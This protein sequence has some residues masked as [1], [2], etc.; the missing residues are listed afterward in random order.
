VSDYDKWH[1][2]VEVQSNTD[3]E[4]TPP[5]MIKRFEQRRIEVGELSGKK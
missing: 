1:T 3:I 5:A 4:G 2:I